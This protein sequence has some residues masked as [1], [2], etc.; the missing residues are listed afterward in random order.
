M[1]NDDN[2][3][4]FASSKSLGSILAILSRISVDAVADI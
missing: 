3:E 4:I 1:E 2:Q